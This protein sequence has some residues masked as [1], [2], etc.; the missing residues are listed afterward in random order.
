VN[1]GVSPDPS[2]T[3]GAVAT[4]PVG[5]KVIGGGYFASIAHPVA[6][7]PAAD[8]SGWIAVLQNQSSISVSGYAFAACSAK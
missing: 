8:G 1:L 4:C 3:Q 5:T 7:E 2:Y 6:S